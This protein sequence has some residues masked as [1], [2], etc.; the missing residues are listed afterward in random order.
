MNQRN[1]NLRE[2]YLDAE[3][4]FRKYVSDGV[5]RNI[6]SLTEW[7]IAEGMTSSNGGEPTPMGCWKAMWR[8]ASTHKELAWELMKDETFGTKRRPIQYTREQWE[9]DMILIKIPSAWQ[10]TTKSKYDKFLREHGWKNGS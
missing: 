7:A 9:A 2:K 8:W 4:L 3:R 5:S 10:H 6:K 1:P